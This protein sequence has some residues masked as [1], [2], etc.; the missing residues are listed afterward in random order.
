MK[1]YLV[2]YQSDETLES[3]VSRIFAREEDAIAFGNEI[4]NEDGIEFGY[5]VWV[6]EWAVWSSAS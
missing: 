6:E 3:E 4:A 5:D 2:F 1:V